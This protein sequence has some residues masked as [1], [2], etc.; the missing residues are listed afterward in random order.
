MKLL[1]SWL[2]A[3]IPALG[4]TIDVTNESAAYIRPDSEVRIDFTVSNYAVNN[5]EAPAYPTHLELSLIGAVPGAPP[6]ALPGST[7]EY[8]PGFLFDARLESRDASASVEFDNPLLLEP[9]TFWAPSGDAVQIA[10][11]GGA[12]DLPPALARVIFGPCGTA[13]FVLRNRGDE[14]VLGAG[15][16]YRVRNS[17]LIPDVR[18]E[19]PRAVSGIVRTVTVA[20][21]EPGTTVLLVAGGALMVMLRAWRRARG[22]RRARSR[23]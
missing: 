16:D 12:I 18:G 21:P 20:N 5:P 2:L 8:Y 1:F 17:V 11:L 13:R 22:Y 14:F 4:G 15:G 6:A 3:A 9:G 19:G 10:L 7:R 23:A